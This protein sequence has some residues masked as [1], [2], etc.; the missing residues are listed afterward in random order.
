MKIQK[1]GT[2]IH[3]NGMNSGFAVNRLQYP[4]VAD[5]PH[6]GDKPEFDSQPEQERLQ[7]PSITKQEEA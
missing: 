2:D 6:Q 4:Q 3:N 1:V 5:L 7:I